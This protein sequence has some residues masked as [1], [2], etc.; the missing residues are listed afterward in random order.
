MAHYITI[1]Q[2]PG[3]Y[4]NL[5]ICRVSLLTHRSVAYLSRRSLSERCDSGICGGYR[6]AVYSFFNR[7]HNKETAGI[8][9]SH[10][11]LII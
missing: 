3:S 10:R 5:D 4:F 9:L 11:I 2:S 6:L 7:L 8:S 1:K